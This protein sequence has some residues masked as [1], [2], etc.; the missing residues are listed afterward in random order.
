[1]NEKWDER[2][3]ELAKHVAGW[4]R[5]PSTK[6]GAVIVR[7]DKTI[8]SLGFNGFARGVKDR[9]E[10]YRDRQEKYKRIIHADMNAL[11]FLR[12]PAQ[13]MTMYTWP[14]LP[15]NRCAVHIIQAGI[16]EVVSVTSQGDSRWEE[17]VGLAIDMMK[18]AGIMVRCMTTNEEY[19]L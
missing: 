18:E 10:L 6:V 19:D 4:S 3:L 12:E 13:G 11:L 5:D 15:C 7:P 16:V 14:M 2:F 8:A 17:E 1:M 9:E